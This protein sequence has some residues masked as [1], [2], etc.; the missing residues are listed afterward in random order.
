MKIL[1]SNTGFHQMIA[2]EKERERERE[3]ELSHTTFQLAKQYVECHK[4]QTR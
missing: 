4:R 1:F 2:R 3:R